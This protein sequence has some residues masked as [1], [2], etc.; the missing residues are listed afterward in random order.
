MPPP[1][2]LNLNID[3]IS[4]FVGAAPLVLVR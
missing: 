2:P 3:V 4:D 1:K